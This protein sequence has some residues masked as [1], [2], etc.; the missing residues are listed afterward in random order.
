MRLHLVQRSQATQLSSS[1]ALSVLVSLSLLDELLSLEQER[2]R[3]PP[4]GRGIFPHSAAATLWG[5]LPHR[6]CVAVLP[7]TNRTRRVHNKSQKSNCARFPLL[8]F[9]ALNVRT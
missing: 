4:L 7:P 8:G 1:P 9:A 5:R 6:L 3:R 2:A